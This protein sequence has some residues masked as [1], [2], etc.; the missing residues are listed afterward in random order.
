MFNLLKIEIDPFRN[1]RGLETM[2]FLNIFW[3]PV[4]SHHAICGK[5]KID[6]GAKAA[7]IEWFF[8]PWPAYSP[9]HGALFSLSSPILIFVLQVIE[10]K[11]CNKK[12]LKTI[13]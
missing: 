3:G 8:D 5:V 11:I 4:R 2:I 9:I 13:D 10:M 12:S 1:L 6:E 7:K